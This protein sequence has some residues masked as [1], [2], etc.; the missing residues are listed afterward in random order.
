[1]PLEH[2]SVS[3]MSNHAR[4]FL[5]FYVLIYSNFVQLI[6]LY[7]ADTPRYRQFRL[8]IGLLMLTDQHVIVVVVDEIIDLAFLIVVVDM[9]FGQLLEDT[10]I[11]LIK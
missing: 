3:P 8:A 7:P 9:V 10:I 1:M 11:K 2:A 6:Q 4:R 5:A